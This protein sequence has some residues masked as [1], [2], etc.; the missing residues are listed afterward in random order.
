M[1][2]CYLI[3]CSIYQKILV[4]LSY[5]RDILYLLPCFAG[6]KKQDLCLCDLNLE[7]ELIDKQKGKQFVAGEYD[8]VSFDIKVRNTGIEPAYG[9][10][11]Q[12]SANFD[13]PD[14]IGST[15]GT[16]VLFTRTG[17]WTIKTIF[18]F[19]NTLI[20]SLIHF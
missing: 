15:G 8:S 3:N 5:W 10:K 18:K 13:L 4:A 9:S 14:E 20:F 2:K 12:I 16:D 7:S 17:V 6:C 1:R 19:C 11:I